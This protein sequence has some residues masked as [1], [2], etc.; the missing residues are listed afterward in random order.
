MAALKENALNILAY[1]KEN[2]DQDIIAA[3]IA[4]AL[5]MEVK[6][7]NGTVTALDRHRKL[8][9]R[10]PGE[11]ELEDGSHKAVKFIRLTAAG[12]AFDPVTDNH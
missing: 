2:D 9:E 5:G 6:S 10:I 4:D 11:I 8:V 3:D 7:V 1:L 12:K